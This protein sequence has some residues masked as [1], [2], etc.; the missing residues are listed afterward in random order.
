MRGEFI[1]VNGARLYY[2]AAG[3]RGG[4][5][6]IV[7]LHGFPTS[8]HLWARVVPAL[9]DGHRVVVVDLLGY[10]RSD[11]PQGR[12][13]GV[14][15]HAER[16]LELLDVLGINYA[17]V[18][19]HELGA[20]VAQALAVRWPARVARLALVNP[21]AYDEWPVREV[22]LARAMLPLTRHLPATFLLTLL[23]RELLRGY[24]EQE[25][26]AR[27]IDKY[28]KPFA[29]ADGRDALV[30]HLLALDAAETAQLAPR[31][32]DLVMP[33]TV[34]AGAH[35]PF[36]PPAVAERLAADVP[37]AVLEVVPD[38][39]HFLPEDAPRAVA[40]SVA[41]LLARE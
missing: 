32:K 24:A 28:L 18:V 3:T 23:R 21:V 5:E 7:L 40:D 22:R 17:C 4:G 36:L 25:S 10:G 33:T 11:R 8:S 27:S 31:L 29:S 30:E 41:R 19:G 14:R 6:P 37:G 9:P 35:D 13:L 2:Y 15:A 34:L 26:G 16:V 38:A 12:P 39:R 1:D 20:G